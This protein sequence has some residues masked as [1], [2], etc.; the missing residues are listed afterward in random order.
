[1]P[2][3]RLFIGG[4][5]AESIFS[6]K[7]FAFPATIIKIVGKADALG[8]PVRMPIKPPPFRAPG[9]K[10]AAKRKQVQNPFYN[11]R[12]GSGCAQRV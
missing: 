3:P 1:M 8:S 12:C 5:A 6:R 11:R 2:T 7:S 9:W 10:P 4:Y